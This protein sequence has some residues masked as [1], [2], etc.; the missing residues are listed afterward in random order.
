MGKG[1]KGGK[2]HINES[3]KE[4]KENKKLIRN[5]ICGGHEERWI[6]HPE[7]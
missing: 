1:Q 4:S 7:K 3:N 5:K 6:E 2:E